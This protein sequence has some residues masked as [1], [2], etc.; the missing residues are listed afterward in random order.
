[1]RSEIVQAFNNLNVEQRLR[2]MYYQNGVVLF[3]TYDSKIVIHLSC[4]RADKKFYEGI[5][6]KDVV[7]PDNIF[8]YYVEDNGVKHYLIMNSDENPIKELDFKDRLDIEILD[9]NDKITKLESFTE[10]QIFEDLGDKMKFLM[11]A[12]LKTQKLLHEYLIQRKTF[13]E[14]DTYSLNGL[15]S[16]N[17]EIIGEREK[18][19]IKLLELKQQYDFTFLGSSKFHDQLNPLLLQIEL[20]KEKIVNGL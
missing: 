14:T 20:L 13:L 1:M 9:L 6:I 8:E 5:K 15:E 16:V 19:I 10:T 17:A 11:R 4:M 7:L 3:E 12:Q 18:D 2:F